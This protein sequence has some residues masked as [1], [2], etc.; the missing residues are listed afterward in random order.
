MSINQPIKKM[1]ALVLA[2]AAVALA[3][4]IGAAPVAAGASG[5]SAH[6]AHDQGNGMPPILPRESASHLAALE[7]WEAVEFFSDPPANA[8]YS[9]AEFNAYGSVHK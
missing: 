3:V 9:N 8:H 2:A 1:I 4:Q 7:A 5:Q 6:V